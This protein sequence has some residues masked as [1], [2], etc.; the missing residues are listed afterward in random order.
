MKR[1]N[2]N[3]KTKHHI[4]PQSRLEGKGVLNVCKVAEKQHNLYHSLFGNMTPKEIVRFLNKTFWADIY[5]I[6]ITQNRGD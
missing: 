6:D 4:I 1:K 2:Q 3:K 5:Q